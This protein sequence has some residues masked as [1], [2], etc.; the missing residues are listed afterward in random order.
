MFDFRLA[1]A[2]TPRPGEGSD[3]SMTMN[4]EQNIEDLDALLDDLCVEVPVENDHAAAQL[5]LHDGIF[6]IYDRATL[7]LVQQIDFNRPAETWQARTETTG[8]FRGAT[9]RVQ[10]AV[11]E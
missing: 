4:I 3:M 7:D 1:R 2:N 8:D 5:D 11:G 9:I 6:E 10:V